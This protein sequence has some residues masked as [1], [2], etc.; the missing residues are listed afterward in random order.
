[1]TRPQ[2]PTSI[3]QHGETSMPVSP[4]R[5]FQSGREPLPRH[6]AKK[7]PSIVALGTASALLTYSTL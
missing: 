2:I 5:R 1:M 3:T 6:T 7:P 4:E